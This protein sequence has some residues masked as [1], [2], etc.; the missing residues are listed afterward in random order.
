MYHKEKITREWRIRCAWG[1][2]IQLENT[3]R[4]QPIFNNFILL[5]YYSSNYY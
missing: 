4:T 5:Y 2:W 3:A 1:W